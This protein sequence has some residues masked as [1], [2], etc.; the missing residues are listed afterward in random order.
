MEDSE[1]RVPQ[2]GEV[3]EHYKGGLYQVITVG[4]LSEKRDEIMVVYRSLERGHVWIRPFA[5]WGQ[6]IDGWDGRKQR[7][8]L[9]SNAEWSEHIAK[10]QAES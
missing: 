1:I 4:R 9:L 7:F 2:P 5:M 3:F 8:R 6:Y 10:G